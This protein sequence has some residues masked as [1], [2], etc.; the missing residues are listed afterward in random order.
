MKNLILDNLLKQNIFINYI[1]FNNYIIIKNGFFLFLVYTIK[2]MEHNT[3]I[4][5]QHK[6]QQHKNTGPESIT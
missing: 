6:T 5:Q 1:I 3:I 4:A 2:Q